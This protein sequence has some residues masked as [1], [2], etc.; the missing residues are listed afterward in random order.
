L[1][2]EARREPAPRQQGSA[3]ALRIGTLTGIPIRVHVTFFILLFWF[4]SVSAGEGRGFFGGIL[5]LLLL[6]GCVVLHELGHATMARRY[7]VRTSEIVL[8]PIGGI[9]R[10]ERMPSG[11][12]ELWIALA[13]PAV[14]VV[15]AALL[16]ATLRLTGSRS[17]TSPEDLV[18]GAPI[19]WQLLVANIILFVFNLIPAFPMD[20]GRVLRAALSLAIGQTRATTVA[21]RVG[22]G[23][24]ILFAILALYPPPMRPVLLLIAFFVFVGAGQEEAYQRG[25]AAV[26]G[27]TAREAMVTRF[28]SLAPQDSLGRAA[29]LLLA[30]HQ[31]DF[32]VV[33][34]WGRVAGI[35]PRSTLLAALAAG[36]RERAVLEAMDREVTTVAAD[37]PLE[38]VLTRF[39]STAFKPIVVVGERGLEG[40]I[41]LENLSELIEIHRSLRR[42][43]EQDAPA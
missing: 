1:S 40:M 11:K 25:R 13:G 43:G 3:W 19:L 33:D 23:V 39:Q 20:G 26:T 10:L 29:E 21:A 17:P 8:Y 36:G 2:E 5:F 16:W 34:L 6:F 30:T 31:Q 12:A 32:P 7:G 41:T 18:A 37:T 15:L 42:A 4:G 27:R 24:A 9:A 38:E 28:E 14:N 22:Q 35:L